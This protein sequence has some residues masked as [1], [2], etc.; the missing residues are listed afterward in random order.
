MRKLRDVLNKRFRMSREAEKFMDHV[1]VRRPP[2]LRQ[3]DQIWMDAPSLYTTAHVLAG[4]I[5]QRDVVFLGEWALT[6]PLLWLCKEKPRCTILDF[7]EEILFCADS[8]AQDHGWQV[9]V[10]PYNV[11]WAVRAPYDK[12]FDFFIT[13]PP[14]GRSNLGESMFI[15]LKRCMDLCHSNGSGGCIIAPYY[16][17][18]GWTKQVFLNLE[19]FLI[20]NGFVIVDV[21]Q[22][23]Q[24][25]HGL[26]KEAPLES[27]CVIVERVEDH[28]SG[29]GGTQIDLP[30][31]FY[32]KGMRGKEF[33]DI[34]SRKDRHKYLRP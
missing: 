10:V 17:N 24:T 31:D 30:P 12:R 3:F 4:Y 1:A 16:P 2:A 13:N 32:G 14:F 11:K 33:P 5:A 18:I 28:Q 7:D 19:R 26:K 25:Y 23:L 21:V 22:G 34:I 8:F 9:E 29:I 20:D 6:F 15:F 27:G